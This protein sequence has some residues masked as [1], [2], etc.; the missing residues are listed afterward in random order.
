MKVTLAVRGGNA[1][2]KEIPIRSPQF[3]IGRDDSC[4][5][6][7]SSPIVSKLHCA[8]LIADGAVW[9]RDLKSTNGTF[10]NGVKVE[11]RQ[12]A[13]HG[14]QLRV[15]PLELEIR[16]EG[17]AAAEPAKVEKAKPPAR[18]SK[19][20][21][22]DEISD[23][24]SDEDEDGVTQLDEPAAHLDQAT[25]ADVSLGESE[26]VPEMDPLGSPVLPTKPTVAEPVKDTSSAAADILKAGFAR[27][28][29]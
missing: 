10:V 15:G 5:L 18:A 13:K 14:D 28:K 2:G 1:A 29:K 19:K 3:L 7:P 21:N 26:T 22:E 9:V 23:W 24:L 27:Y 11:D 8:I 12:L 20:I 17:G 4:N 16:I 6:R 25:I